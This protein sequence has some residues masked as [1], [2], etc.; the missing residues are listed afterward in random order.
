MPSPYYFKLITFLLLLLHLHPGINRNFII[1]NKKDNRELTSGGCSYGPKV[2]RFGF[3]PKGEPVPPSGPSKRHNEVFKNEGP[4]TSSTAAA[5]EKDWS[6]TTLNRDQ[7]PVFS[8]P[9][10]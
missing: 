9:S 7:K 10:C 8:Y 2:A 6:V 1:N 5:S 4:P 3:F